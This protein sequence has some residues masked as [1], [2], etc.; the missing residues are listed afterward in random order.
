MANLHV[1]LDFPPMKVPSAED[2]ASLLEESR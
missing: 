1:L 2:F